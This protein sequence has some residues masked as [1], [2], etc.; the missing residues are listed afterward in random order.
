MIVLIL[1]HTHWIGLAHKLSE[2]N[3]FDDG[4]TMSLTFKPHEAYWGDVRVD[5]KK[6]RRVKVVN[7]ASYTSYTAERDT[8]NE[9]VIH[10]ENK[11]KSMGWSPIAEDTKKP[12]MTWRNL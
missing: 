5:F 3:Y 1:P 8:T 2:R 12:Q 6:G 10:L 9:D 7:G 4:K 11:L